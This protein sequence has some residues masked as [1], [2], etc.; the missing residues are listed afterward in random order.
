MH[1]PSTSLP[2]VHR[3]SRASGFSLFELVLVLF[4]MT[5]FAGIAA[6]SLAPSARKNMLKKNADA[7]FALVLN[8]QTQAARTGSMTEL[9]LNLDAAKAQ[10]FFIDAD[11]AARTLPGDAG[12]VLTLRDGREKCAVKFTDPSGI[13]HEDGEICVRFDPRGQ[14]DCG[15]A[16]LSM[17]SPEEC[18]SVCFSD[19]FAPTLRTGEK[20][21]GRP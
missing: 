11:N 4:L 13:V 12:D 16:R 20:K 9:R 6:A 8:C 21:E 14:C 5:L 2:K 10:A 19:G 7:L 1:Q 18:E 17:E 3:A 15:G